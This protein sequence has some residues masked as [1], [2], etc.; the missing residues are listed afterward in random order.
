MQKKPYRYPPVRIPKVL[1]LHRRVAEG[2]ATE[3]EAHE[4]RRSMNVLR[5]K[6]LNGSLSPAN[7]RQ[8][9]FLN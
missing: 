3:N 1:K 8:L 4:Y 5:G 9:G 6:F 2:T 7:A